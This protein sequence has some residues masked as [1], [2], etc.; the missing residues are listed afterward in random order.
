MTRYLVIRYHSGHSKEVHHESHSSSLTHEPT[1]H[2]NT[3]KDKLNNLHEAK[4][5]P[6]EVFANELM[7]YEPFIKY[8]QENGSHFTE[9]LA[10]YCISRH[11]GKSHR[12]SKAILEALEG[13]KMKL[14]KDV[15]LGDFTY[16]VNTKY[17]D[18][19]D[20]IA[21]ALEE[22]KTQPYSGYIFNRWLADHI[23]MGHSIPWE[24]FI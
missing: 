19:P 4:G 23:G 12:N 2:G 10:D 9:Y 7:E 17:K 8:L 16:L 15:T 24:E 14:P 20:S 18:H 6:F 22:L 11:K 21:K 3:L 1:Y 5:I 13:S